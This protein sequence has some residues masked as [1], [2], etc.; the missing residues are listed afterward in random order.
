MGDNIMAAN[1]EKNMLRFA[2]FGVRNMN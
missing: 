2:V 1:P